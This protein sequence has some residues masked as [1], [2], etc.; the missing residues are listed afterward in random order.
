MSDGQHRV[1]C[2]GCG[3]MANVTISENTRKMNFDCPKC[4]TRFTVTFKADE[5]DNLESYALAQDI[6]G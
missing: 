6:E 1:E 3:K 2:P 4:K 5:E